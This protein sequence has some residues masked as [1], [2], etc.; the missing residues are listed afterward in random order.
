MKNLILLALV[1]GLIFFLSS[2]SKKE[3]GICYC[4]YFKG[5]NKQFDLRS[6]DK[7]AQEDSCHVISSNA[8]HFGGSCSLK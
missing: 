7:A 6:L 1:A 8:S 2:C 4:K 3:S 5:D